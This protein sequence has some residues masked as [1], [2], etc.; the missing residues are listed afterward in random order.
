MIKTF[1]GYS[2]RS[3]Q[4]AINDV[5]KKMQEHERYAGS[6]SLKVDVKST[7]TDIVPFDNGFRFYFTITMKYGE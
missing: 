4:E 3:L 2:D 6:E 7:T 5:Y 1:M